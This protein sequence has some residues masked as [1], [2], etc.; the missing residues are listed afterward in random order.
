MSKLKKERL[1]QMTEKAL[2]YKQ[3]VSHSKLFSF[4]KSLKILNF[5]SKFYGL[6]FTSIFAS[7]IFIFPTITTNDLADLN[8][9][10]DY[11]TFIII[12]DL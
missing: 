6:T 10:N 12:K 2:S 11:I 4:Y 7:F 9:I 3:D 5:K 8:E 1:N